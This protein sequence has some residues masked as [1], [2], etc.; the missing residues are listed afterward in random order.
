MSEDFTCFWILS[1]PINSKSHKH[2]QKFIRSHNYSILI[3]VSILYR[4]HNR[5]IYYDI[6]HQSL[7]LLLYHLALCVIIAHN[8][9]TIFFQYLSIFIT[10]TV[11]ALGLC[12]VI[13]LKI[14]H[15]VLISVF[16]L[17][18]VDVV[19]HQA[20]WFFNSCHFMDSILVIFGCS[21]SW[22]HLVKDKQ[23]ALAYDAYGPEI[24]RNGPVFG[25]HRCVRFFSFECRK[26]GMY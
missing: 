5:T 4:I 15:S 24:Y 10:N 20:I 1:F 8:M 26:W 17:I 11:D 19:D 23:I 12:P 14:T 3:G 6:G 25:R 13:W 9:C 21:C 7:N 2:I 16:R 22:T 18:V